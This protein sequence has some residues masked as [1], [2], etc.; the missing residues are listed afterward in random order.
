MTPLTPIDPPLDGLQ[1]RSFPEAARAMRA[2]SERIMARWLRAVQNI[3]PAAEHLTLTQLR[4]HVPLMVEQIAAALASDR[5][6]PTERLAE[7]SK[8]HGGVRFHQAYNVDELLIEYHLLRGIILEEVAAH[9]GRVLTTAESVAINVDLDTAQRQ[10]V[11]RFVEHL[12]GQL[13]ASDDL[14]S[15]YISYLN[16]DLRGGMNGI[17]LMVE[18]LKRQLSVEPRFAEAVEDLDAMRRSVL[19]SV[20]TMDRFVFAHRLGRGQQQARYSAV[21]VKSLV[22]ETVQSLSHIAMERHVEF[23]VEVSENCAVESDRDLLRLILQNLLGNTIK[24]ARREGGHVKF[25]AEPQSSGGCVFTISDDGPGIGESLLDQLY[26]SSSSSGKGKQGF[27]LGLPVSKMAADLLGA[28]LAV[29]SVVGKGT[30][31]RLAVPDHA[32]KKQESVSVSGEHLST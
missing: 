4:D 1:N 13:K 27:K 6:A 26:I 29:E 10:G 5:P 24:H 11:V 12:T 8:P 17:M 21:N 3:L 2:G 22:H 16:H 23:A 20:T 31:V 7:G 18:V 30:V 25:C 19:D 28:T 14:Q 15:N 32:L 9:L